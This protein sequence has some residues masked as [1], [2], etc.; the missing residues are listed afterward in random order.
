MFK[1]L[2]LCYRVAGTQEEKDNVPLLKVKRLRSSLV[3]KSFFRPP[4]RSGDH[5]STR[6]VGPAHKEDLEVLYEKMR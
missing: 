4:M 6:V 3:S 5:T 2:G 1:S